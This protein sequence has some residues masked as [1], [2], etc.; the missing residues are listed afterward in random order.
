[1]FMRL[2]APPLQ[3]LEY[4]AHKR[5]SLLTA[6]LVRLNCL[7]IP[8]PNT[9]LRTCSPAP[10]N[11]QSPPPAAIP[12]ICRTRSRSLEVTLQGW[13]AYRAAQTGMD[14]QLQS[15]IT[16]LQGGVI[17]ARTNSFKAELFACPQGGMDRQMRCMCGLSHQAFFHMGAAIIRT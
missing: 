15:M 12:Q 10:R 6:I 2:H 9:T 13:L 14:K 1:M 11:A 5:A 8:Y 16:C 17:Y 4:Y 3:V 7:A